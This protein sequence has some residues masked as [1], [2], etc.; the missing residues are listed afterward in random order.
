[1]AESIPRGD[2]APFRVGNSLFF[3]RSNRKTSL[4]AHPVFD[5]RKRLSGFSFSVFAPSAL[6]VCVVCDSN[7]WEIG[8]FPLTRGENGVWTGFFAGLDVG[9]RYKFCITAP[10]GE[11][12]YRADPC[13]RYAELR[14][15]T[16]SRLWYDDYRWGDGEYAFGK[17]FDRPLS[18]YEVHLGSW[19]RAQNGDMLSYRELAGLLS[20][21]VLKM[22][23][24]HIELLPVS[25]HPY[26][27]SWGYQPTGYFAPT[28]RH[29]T[30]EDFK[31]FVDTMHSR[32]IGVIL[33]WV[34]AHFP[35]DEAGLRMFDGSPLFEPS[36]PDIA[37]R[38]GWGTLAFDY[39]KPHTRDFLI[40]NALFWLSE[41]H[42]DGL[43]VDAVSSI[44]YNDDGI[45]NAAGAAFIRQLNR[46]VKRYFPDRMMVAEE[47]SDRA[48]VTSPFAKGGLGFDYKWNM[49]WMNDTLKYVEC[50]PLFRP[51]CHNL[52]TFSMMYA[53]SERFILP[54]SHDECVHGKKSLI[55]KQSGE[56]L[57][58]FASLKTY[59]T[60][61]FSHP[62]KKLLF[63]GG[64]FGQF[65]EWRYYEALEWA[66]LKYD[67]HRTL[68][69]FV[70]DL[71]RFYR[72]HAALW[73]VDDCWDGF[74]WLEPNDRRFSV[75]SYLRTDGEETLLILLN[76]TPVARPDYWVGS[77]LCGEY[78]LL[79]NTDDSKYGGSGAR[80]KK[81][82]RTGKVRQGD[83]PY[84][85]K[86]SLPP[87]SA[88]IYRFKRKREKSL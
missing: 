76:F 27:G 75:F 43:R 77:P 13:A 46:A 79:L 51:G 78:T 50:D 42:I 73:K 38:K 5:R 83:F 86:A 55:E 7:G 56:Y 71:N 48:G 66:L 88:L 14:P 45:E 3:Q 35:K 6:E 2:V 4:G 18:I 1:M 29:G 9:E 22:G 20:D 33:D 82:M 69:E 62:G 80:V 64:E 54:L 57:L 12:L 34:P 39:S 47:S 23:F 85:L 10:S 24:T 44:I 31:Y 17:G 21:Y 30:P 63:M 26:D 61:M 16:A 84:R 40:S 15:A 32:G 37:Q 53:F 11:R 28:S 68:A 60:Y 74:K 65:I 72:K 8:A 49:G 41:Y 52:M 25:E 70:G 59:F 36:D 81:S 67:T 87:M 58:K 19:M